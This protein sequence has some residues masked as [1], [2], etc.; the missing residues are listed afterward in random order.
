M[1]L[2]HSPFHLAKSI[3]IPHALGAVY[4]GAREARVGAN[5]IVIGCAAPSRSRDLSA[6]EGGLRRH[7]P[8]EV[9]DLVRQYLVAL[10]VPL[11]LTGHC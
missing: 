2:G 9:E 4:S 10:S 8:L 3:T 5:R 7:A 11:G 6:S 1:L